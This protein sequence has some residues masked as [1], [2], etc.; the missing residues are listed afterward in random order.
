MEW[1]ARKR[2]KTEKK[3]DYTNCV[4]LNKKINDKIIKI[5]KRNNKLYK[6]YDSIYKQNLMDIHDSFIDV[7]NIVFIDNQPWDVMMLSKQWAHM[8]CSTDMQTPSPVFPFNPFTKKNINYKDIKNYLEC[9]EINKI[10]I[11]EPL[12]YILKN[13]NKLKYKELYNTS[14]QLNSEL[15]DILEEKYRFKLINNKNSQDC[16]NGY[17]VKK[18]S[19]YSEFERILEYYESIP[20]QIM[21]YFGDIYDNPEKIFAKFQLDMFPTEDLIIN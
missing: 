14:Y 19:R 10:K 16:Y 1:V 13:Y 11:Y 8:I 4:D 7:S 12:K 9:I 17:W 21:G 5:Y 20:F 6:I 3:Y 18:N 15:I 2:I